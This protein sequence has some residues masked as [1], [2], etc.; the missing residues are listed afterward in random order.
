M[1]ILNKFESKVYQATT[2]SLKIF[3]SFDVD[4]DV[5]NFFKFFLK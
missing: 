5:F 3:R 4:G 1:N 2:P